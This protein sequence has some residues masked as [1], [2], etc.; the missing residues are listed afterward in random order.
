[1]F[2]ADVIERDAEWFAGASFHF[3]ETA[4]DAAQG[5]HQIV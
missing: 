2:G 3:I 1:V 5:I 4:L